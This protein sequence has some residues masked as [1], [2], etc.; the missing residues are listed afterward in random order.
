M[1]GYVR[2]DVWSL[3]GYFVSGLGCET[4]RLVLGD[5][6]GDSRGFHSACPDQSVQTGL[7][8]TLTSI[9]SL[10]IFLGDGGGTTVSRWFWS[11][12]IVAMP[13][14]RRCNLQERKKGEQGE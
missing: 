5:R 9:D 14:S 12:P 11:S 4:Q 6:L 7:P 3:T 10:A 2:L 1:L 8:R 13:K